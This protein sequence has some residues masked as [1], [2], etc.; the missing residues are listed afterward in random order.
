[1]ARKVKKTNEALKASQPWTGHSFSP[2]SSS[3][4][5]TVV[6]TEPTSKTPMNKM[7]KI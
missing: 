4:S 6:F 1:M 5:S 7:N 2:S 3:S